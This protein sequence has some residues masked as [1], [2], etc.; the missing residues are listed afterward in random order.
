MR[1]YYSNYKP[2]KPKDPAAQLAK[3]RKKNPDIQ[4]VILEGKNLAKSWWAKAWNKNLESYA[5]YYSRI[6]RGRSYVRAGAV[7]DLLISPGL[8]TAIIQGSRTKPYDVSINIDPLSPLQWKAITEKCNRKFANIE[9]LATGKFPTELEDLFTDLNSGL[10]PT[11]QDI[12]F[13][14]TCPDWAYMCKHIAATLY[15]IGARF[16]QD[17]LLFFLLRDIDFSELIKK[18][19]DDKMAGLLKNADKKSERV[20]ED[21]DIAE[22]FDV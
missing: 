14:C 5:D 18:T 6:G 22:L 15:G 12:H 7:L 2:G 9:E 20:I 8:V 11:P 10:F 4:P 17:P 21:R 3:L 13:Y 1:G 19:V 16:D